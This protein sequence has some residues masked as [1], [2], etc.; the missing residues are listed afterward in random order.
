MLER[1]LVDLVPGSPHSEDHGSIEKEVVGFISD[2]HWLFWN[3]SASIFYRLEEASRG[4]QHTS[5]IKPHQRI[6]KEIDA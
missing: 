3:N 1:A 4:S 2:T 6:K 5:S